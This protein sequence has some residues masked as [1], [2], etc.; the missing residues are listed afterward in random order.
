MRVGTLGFLDGDHTLVIDLGHRLGDQLAD[1]V[2]VVGRDRS[3]LLDLREVRADLLALCTQRLDNLGH[4]LV[5]TALEVHRVGTGGHVLQAH[6]DD[7]LCKHRCRRCS[8][9]GIVV[10]LR[11]DLLDHLCTHVGECILE[12]NLLGDRHTVLGD[13]GSTELLVDNHVATL[14]AQRYLHCVRQRIDTLLEEFA[15]LDIVF[16]IL[17]HGVFRFLDV[18]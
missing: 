3:H 14:G 10:G 6:T 4:G 13:L 2:V 11:S 16:D 5:D 1:V 17:C 8:V 9:T 15:R 18:D 12:L 7:R